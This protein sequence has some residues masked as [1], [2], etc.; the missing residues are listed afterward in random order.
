MIIAWCVLAQMHAV[1]QRSTPSATRRGGVQFV[2]SVSADTVYAGAPLLYDGIVRLDTAAHIRFLVPPT[3]TPPTMPGAVVYS[4]PL[5]ARATVRGVRIGTTTYMEYRYHHVLFPLTSGTDTISATTV[6]FTRLNEADPYASDSTTLRSPSR[7]V[8]VLPLPAEGRPPDF[9][10]AVGQ[11]TIS[12]A[13]DTRAW[14]VGQGAVV[15]AR[16]SGTSNVPLIPRPALDIP[17]ATVLATT[18]SV[19][20][21]SAAQGARGFREFRWLVT[22][23]SGGRRVIPAVKYSVFDPSTARYVTET[24]DAIPLLIT[25]EPMA[26]RDTVSATPF[27][28]LVRVVLQYPIRVVLVGIALVLAGIAMYR[29]FH[30]S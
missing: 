12:I 15:R 4:V 13:L 10:G 21:D 19:A 26:S 3:Y 20:W 22:P 16:V 11:L 8:V 2:M 6:R 24:T 5:R 18:D 25:G 14:R 1:P 7:T 9:S 28:A 17:W 29:M 30:L 23:Q 27:P